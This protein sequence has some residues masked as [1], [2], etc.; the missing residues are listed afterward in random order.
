MNRTYRSTNYPLTIPVTYIQGTKDGATTAESAIFHYKQTA[1]KQ[2]QIVLVK[3]TGHSPAMTCMNTSLDTKDCANVGA[4][5]DIV[6]TGLL[7]QELRSEQILKAGA[8]WKYTKKNF[9][10]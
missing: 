7:G 6:R 5:A 2:A 8:N 1:Q 9:A 3:N 10:H 4:I